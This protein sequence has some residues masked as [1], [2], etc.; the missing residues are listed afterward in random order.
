M[1]AASFPGGTSVSRLSVYDSPAPDGLRGGSPHLHLVSAESY[2]VTGGSGALQTLGDDGFAE[3]PLE[4]GSVIWFTP[5]TIHR[6]INHGGLE[7]TVIMQNAGLPEAGDAVMTFPD[8]HLVT[9]E[10]YD[11]VATLPGSARAEAAM[12][13]RD[14]A[15]LGFLALR[16]GGFERFR[17]RAVALVE[18]RVAEWRSR[19]ESTVLEQTRATD[20]Q[21]VSLAGGA[22]H[23]AP[24]R[25]HVGAASQALGMC[26]RLTVVDTSAR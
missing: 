6:A 2:V 15:V 13:R 24:A 11:A 4:T 18:P 26:G 1:T 19:W 21:L 22:W 23:G 16:E 20:A 5:G 12:R 25:V 8:E 3:T 10:A 7:V 14:L 9:R 17:E